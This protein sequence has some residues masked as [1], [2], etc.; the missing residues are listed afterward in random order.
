MKMNYFVLALLAGGAARA[1]TDP[2]LARF[3]ETYK[4]LV[5]TNTTL[6]SGDSSPCASSFL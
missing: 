1:Q 5:E 3:R 6:S 2:S 4:E